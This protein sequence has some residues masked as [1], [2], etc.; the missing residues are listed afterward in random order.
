[1]ELD[2]ILVIRRFS[3]GAREVEDQGAAGEN[4]SVSQL[5]RAKK[6]TSLI[7]AFRTDDA[8]AFRPIQIEFQEGHQLPRLHQT[9]RSIDRSPVGI[10]MVSKDLF[11]L[12]DL[13]GNTR[14][15]LAVC[16][17]VSDLVVAL[18]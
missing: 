16:S 7:R 2:S 8:V 14:F 3:T 11:A 10:K 9:V 6:E 15:Q 12:L 5:H 13:L 4:Q 1:M 17:H 18:H